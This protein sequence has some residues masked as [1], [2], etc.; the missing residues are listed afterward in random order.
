MDEFLFLPVVF[1]ILAGIVLLLKKEY[2]KRNTLL[3]S[4]GVVLVIT[5]VLAF[6]GIFLAEDGITAFYLTK[7][8]PIF[9]K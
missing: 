7:T 3:V 1:P 2:Q 4:V 8:L 9:L 6:C 5:G